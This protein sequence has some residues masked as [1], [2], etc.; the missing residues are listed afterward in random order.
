LTISV[1]GVSR[2]WATADIWVA[3]GGGSVLA[4]LVAARLGHGSASIPG[5]ERRVAVTVASGLGVVLLAFFEWRVLPADWLGIALATTALLLYIVGLTPT[6]SLLRGAGYLLLAVGAARSLGAVVSGPPA[7]RFQVWAAVASLGAIYVATLTGRARLRH[8]QG[9]VESVVR[10]VLPGFATFS[11]AWLVGD[12]MRASLVTLTWGL[13]GLALL[14]VGFPARERALRLSGLAML[15]L[16]V[17]KLFIYDLSELEALP[18]IMSFV[19]LGLVLLGVSWA[20][21]RVKGSEVGRRTRS[22]L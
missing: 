14:V 15:T 20:Y 17:L 10:A 4:W 1:F 19:V 3:L 16:C 13:V 18:R 5:P 11:V 22:D 2:A 8:Q 9:G 7:T 12:E 6:R 21:T